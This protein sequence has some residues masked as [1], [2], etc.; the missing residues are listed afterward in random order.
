M[1]DSQE[2]ANDV[3]TG[4]VSLLRKEILGAFPPI[5]VVHNG[6]STHELIA[7]KEIAYTR[8]NAL[9]VELSSAHRDLGDLQ[10]K[11]DM[12]KKAGTFEFKWAL[13]HGI[14]CAQDREA[15][16]LRAIVG[17]RESI[18]R[19]RAELAPLARV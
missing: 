19:L 10:N 3:S 9:Q 11:I 2:C 5:P 15:V 7:A 6:S 8:M 17:S 13:A 14:H 1:S 18:A 16:T 4:S 12:I